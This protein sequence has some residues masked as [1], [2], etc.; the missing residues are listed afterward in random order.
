MS[1]VRLK[2]TECL[3]QQMLF[4]KSNALQS[5]P[6]CL[7]LKSL[8]RDSTLLLFSLKSRTIAVPVQRQEY[9]LYKPYTLLHWSWFCVVFTMVRVV[10]LCQHRLGAWRRQMGC[11]TEG[12]WED[13]SSSHTIF[14][15]HMSVSASSCWALY[16]YHVLLKMQLC[17]SCSVGSI[18]SIC[19]C[20]SLPS[21][22][23]KCNESMTAFP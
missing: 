15:F 11:E 16:S 6:A 20:T 19:S 9:T 5:Y 10:P 21:S 17:H 13:Y 18:W 4:S 22:V 1:F 14:H 3:V 8:Q 23:D 7:S 2:S 12:V